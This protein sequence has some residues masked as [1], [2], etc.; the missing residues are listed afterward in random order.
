MFFKLVHLSVN[1]ACHE[2]SCW[3]VRFPVRD[4]QNISDQCEIRTSIRC[5][6]GYQAFARV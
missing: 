2:A 1:G 5:V 4:P 3:M 6:A